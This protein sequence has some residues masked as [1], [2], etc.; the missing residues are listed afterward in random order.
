MV[1]NFPVGGLVKRWAIG[2]M[3]T[4]TLTHS[5]EGKATIESLFENAAGL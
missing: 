3:Y 2:K 5:Q 4:S 1:S